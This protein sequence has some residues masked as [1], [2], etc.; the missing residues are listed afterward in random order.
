MAILHSAAEE[1]LRNRV[2]LALAYF[3]ALRREELVRLEVSDIDFSR[4]LIT[5][6]PDTTKGGRSRIVS[7]ANSVG[8]NLVLYVA[9]RHRLDRRPG[10]LFLSTS[11]RN[12]GA[13]LSKW[14]WSK[15]VKTIADRAGVPGFSTH[16]LRHLRLTHLARAGWR[17]HEIAAYAGHRNPKSTMTYL[18][19]S[20]AELTSRIAQTVGPR[21]ESVNAVL[22]Q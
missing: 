13:S 18:H 3:G 17:L 10:P 7:Y 12:R 19:L 16:T 15:T 6:R 11:N 8:S 22:F 21:D 1:S 4:R 5:L 20:G 2:M 14:Q 9:E